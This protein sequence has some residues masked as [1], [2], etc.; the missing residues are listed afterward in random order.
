MSASDPCAAEG[1]SDPRGSLAL[2]ASARFLLTDYRDVLLTVAE[3]RG[4]SFQVLTNSAIRFWVAL[5]RAAFSG[6]AF[7]S[8]D[9]FSSRRR[10][11]SLR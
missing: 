6:D 5:F 7:F 2:I 8:M 10:E 3:G 1:P 11:P 9:S 4:L